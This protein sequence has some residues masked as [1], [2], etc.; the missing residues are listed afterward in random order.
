M[1]R[2]L[3]LLAALAASVAP[4]A[5]AASGRLPDGRA[6]GGVLRIPF[7]KDDGSL[8]PYTFEQG[9]ALLTLLYDTLLWRDADG[10]PRPWLARSVETSPD[11]RRVTV[12]IDSAAR[13]H[14]GVAV[15]AAD[16]AFT[17][18]LFAQR[19]H[20]RFTPQ[21]RAVERVEA[22][23]AATAV[24]V[25][26][27][28]SPGFADQ[29]LADLPV[30]PAH[31]WA[32]LP[33]GRPAPPGLPVGS[34]PYRLAEHRP[35]ERYRF[36]AN[37]SYFRGAPAVRAIEVPFVDD[38]DEMVRL[39]R[40][41][42][43]D[44]VPVSLPAASADAVVGLGVRVASGP[45]YSG[46][47][48][49]FNVRRAPFDRVEVRQA[50]SR[51]LDRRRIARAVPGA[52]PASRGYLHPASPW[53]EG[54]PAGAAGTASPGESPGPPPG[55]VPPVEVLVAENDPAKLTAARQVVAALDRAGIDATVAPR[56]RDDLSQAVGEDGSAPTFS[57]AIWTA[58]ALASYDP[59]FL[60]TVF[61]SD[62][63]SAVLNYSG[64]RS[65][66]F[67]ELAERT[68]TAG[69]ASERTAA[70]ADQ[71]RVITEDAPVIPLFFVQGRFA[72]RSA[73]YDGWVFVKGTGILDKRS[74]VEPADETAAVPDGDPGGGPAPEPAAGRGLSLLGW[75]A[76]ALLAAS[77]ATAAAGLLRGRR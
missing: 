69:T 38:V 57:A 55:A 63:R 42:G 53:A 43:V 28:P 30:L 16:V 17:F 33:P 5:T 59:D 7:P 4:A 25:L 31:L 48:L 60:A 46:T 6:T 56:S 45:S 66:A 73:G 40:L 51:A 52:V 26:R 3:L 35:G 39:L 19:P 77:V 29:P 65:A 32:S 58:P 22:V 71:L 12:R 76:C 21:L 27:H 47:V 72:F 64:Y 13:W 75:G 8:T 15:T 70:V 49:M 23:D 9:Y 24:F 41:G 10:V 20:P 62:D 74:F 36:E 68:A 61:G 37:G 67:D 11:Q 34:G 50:V 18:R 44:M 54:V 1:R 2:L 14:D